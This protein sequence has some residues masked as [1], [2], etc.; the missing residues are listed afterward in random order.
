MTTI[1]GILHLSC[2]YNNLQAKGEINHVSPTTAKVYIT[3][4]A[5]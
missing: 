3:I 2:S 4:V 1:A 5:R